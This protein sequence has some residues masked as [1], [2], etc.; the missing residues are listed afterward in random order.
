MQAS[1]QFCLPALQDL[2]PL[3]PV[4]ANAAQ[5]AGTRGAGNAAD[6]RVAEHLQPKGAKKETLESYVLETCMAGLAQC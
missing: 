6:P 2:L 4:F 1:T 3:P 5:G